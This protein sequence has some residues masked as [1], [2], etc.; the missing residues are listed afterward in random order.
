MK[1][2]TFIRIVAECPFFSIDEQVTEKK[3]PAR[4][5]AIRK[6][7]EGR[8]TIKVQKY[9]GKGF[10]IVGKRD[11]KLKVTTTVINPTIFN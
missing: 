10:E 1:S 11:G 7:F 4:L 8:K 2:E 6:M 3:A 5:T 9:Y